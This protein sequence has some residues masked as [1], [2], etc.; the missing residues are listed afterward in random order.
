MHGSMKVRIVKETK[1]KVTLHF[2]TLNRSM[3]ISKKDFKERIE[4]GL[5][6]LVENTPPKS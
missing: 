5:Y 2:I 1:T 3:P 6:E 4:N